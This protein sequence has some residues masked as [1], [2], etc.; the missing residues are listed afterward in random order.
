MVELASYFPKTKQNLER[1]S[2]Q[3]RYKYILLLCKFDDSDK[4]KRFGKQ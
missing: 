3:N 4:N 2:L 1:M